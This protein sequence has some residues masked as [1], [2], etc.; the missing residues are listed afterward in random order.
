MYRCCVERVA[1]VVVGF[2]DGVLFATC[3]KQAG[4]Q[5][6]ERQERIKTYPDSESRVSC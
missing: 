6:E 2:V 4:G 3:D 5:R 1:K